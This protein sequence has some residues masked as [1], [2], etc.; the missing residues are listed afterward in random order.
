ME[1]NVRGKPEP[2]P[3]FLFVPYYNNNMLSQSQINNGLLCEPIACNLDDAN[4]DCGDT[5]NPLALI[6]HWRECA[7]DCGRTPQEITSVINEAMCNDVSHL[8]MTLDRH[9]CEC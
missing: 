6:Q 2:A 8:V 4:A 3:N 9:C 7:I 1:L 5:F